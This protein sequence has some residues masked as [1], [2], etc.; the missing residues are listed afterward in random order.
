MAGGRAQVV[1]TLAVESTGA[2]A[3]IVG[4][5]PGATSGA[6]GL[7]GGTISD[8]VGS[9]ATIR[10]GGIGIASQAALDLIT[11]SSA[12]QFART[13]VGTALQSPRINVAGN[14][15]EFWSPGIAL[16]K[17][18]SGTHTSTSTVNVSTIA[19]ASSLTI[20][21]SLLVV[22]SVSEITQ[23]IIN[24]GLLQNSTD[25]VTVAVLNGGSSYTAGIT[26]RTAEAH[27]IRCDQTSNLL[28]TAFSITN[29]AGGAGN[30][31]STIATFTTAWTGA[32]TLALRIGGVTAGGSCGWSW[33]VYALKG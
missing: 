27:L 18:D 21:D 10:A 9:M 31:I 23:N 24:G 5:A 33:G 29:A 8:S 12:T 16:L 2:N 26:N 7:K 32:W 30:P 25:S 17:S 15:W 13:A 14:G 19:M 6:G 11:A 3:V 20:K 1:D 4:G 22:L 28:S